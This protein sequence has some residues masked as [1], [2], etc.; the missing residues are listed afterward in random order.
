MPW[1]RKL[2]DHMDLFMKSLSKIG[3][4]KLE[5][6][7]LPRREFL[8]RVEVLRRDFTKR[9]MNIVTMIFSF[10]LYLGKEKAIVPKMRDFE[11]TGVSKDKIRGEL[12][13]LVEMNVLDWN[14]EE[15]SFRL[16]DPREWNVK[17][18][19]GYND[20][21]AQEIFILNLKDAGIDPYSE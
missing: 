13:Q 4:N 20:S 5:N 21:R 6:L 15:N 2:H 17:Y 7:D 3:A 8:V 10:S 1:A 11:I 16:K 18:H 19:S 14:K 12:T 9:Q